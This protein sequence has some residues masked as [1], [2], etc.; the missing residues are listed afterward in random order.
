MKSIV[1]TAVI[2]LLIF[3]LG[4]AANL[5]A[6]EKVARKYNY[7]EFKTTFNMPT[8]K[9]DSFG[10]GESKTYLT[11]SNDILFEIDAKDIYKNATGFGINYGQI[12]G[13]TSFNIGFNFTSVPFEDT[14]RVDDAIYYFIDKPRFRL[15]D[16]NL[17]FNYHL[18]DPTLPAISPFI[19]AGLKTGFFNLSYPGFDSENEFTY[20]LGLNFGFDMVVWSDKQKS[21]MVALSSN[22]QYQLVGS[23]IRPKY[24]NIGA[25]VKYYFR[26]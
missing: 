5:H 16:L 19:G 2:A 15:Y 21:S 6:L 3:I 24:I 11:N 12:Q 22:N 25:A 4:I 10:I 8:G 20:T 26:Y 1:K 23:A 18:F 7:L 9:H 17:N 13:N 14:I